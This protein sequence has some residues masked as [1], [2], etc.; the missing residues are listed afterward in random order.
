M[1]F[2]GPAR[3][4]G[5]ATANSCFSEKLLK[6]ISNVSSSSAA[7]SW[8]DFSMTCSSRTLSKSTEPSEIHLSF[9]ESFVIVAAPRTAHRFPS[10][11]IAHRN[12]V[13]LGV[14]DL[15]G[16]PP[17]RHRNNVSMGFEASHEAG[18]RPKDAR[19]GRFSPALLETAERQC[20]VIGPAL[21][22]SFW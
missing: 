16:S 9:N 6:I 18:P 14:F 4:R 3:R 2:R 7:H 19:N 8:S 17:I 12:N 10:K 15:C 22:S 11:P 21:V 1:Y 20:D 5:G 13:S